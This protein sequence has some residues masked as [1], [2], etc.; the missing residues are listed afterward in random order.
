MIF[1]FLVGFQLGPR[2]KTQDFTVFESREIVCAQ[3][4]CQEQSILINQHGLVRWHIGARYSADGTGRVGQ[5]LSLD[6]PAQLL[7]DSALDL[8]DRFSNLLWGHVQTL[9][10]LLALLLLRQIPQKP[11]IATL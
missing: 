8:L 7:A 3:I 10:A 6:L 5:S 11:G 4:L 2:I 9:G 1:F